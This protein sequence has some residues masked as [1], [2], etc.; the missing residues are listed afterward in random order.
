MSSATTT[1]VNLPTATPL[2]VKPRVFAKALAKTNQHLTYRR[3]TVTTNELAM[4][5][6][7]ESIHLP[8]KTS[9][10]EVSG[11]KKALHD[12]QWLYGTLGD[13]WSSTNVASDFPS[14]SPHGHASRFL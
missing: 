8:K 9:F 11:E 14:W 12:E 3:P 2:R 4:P 10:S 13:D 5:S 1:V 7:G 6:A